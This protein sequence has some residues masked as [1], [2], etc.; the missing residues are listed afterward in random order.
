MNISNIF[1]RLRIIRNIF[2]KQ[3]DEKKSFENFKLV[4][5]NGSKLYMS[6]M[7]KFICIIMYLEKTHRY[8]V[9]ISS[10]SDY[11]LLYYNK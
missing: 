7:Q 4:P 3:S 10:L 8:P 11:Y 5:K 9:N 6:K 2:N 1:L